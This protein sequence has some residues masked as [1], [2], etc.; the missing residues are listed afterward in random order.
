MMTLEGS[1]TFN[2]S[3]QVSGRQA[4]QSVDRLLRIFQQV[5]R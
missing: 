2:V 1:G 5:E 4:V 3:G